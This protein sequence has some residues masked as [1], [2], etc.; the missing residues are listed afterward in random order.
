MFANFPNFNS[1][2]LRLTCVPCCYIK[3]GVQ[4]S[5]TTEDDNGRAAGYKRI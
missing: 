2:C 4:V 1:R 3:T 5:D